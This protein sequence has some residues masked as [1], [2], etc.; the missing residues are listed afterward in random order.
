MGYL[1][2]GY[3]NVLASVVWSLVDRVLSSFM[4]GLT[5]NIKDADVDVQKLKKAMDHMPQYSNIIEYVD[6]LIYDVTSAYP[7]GIYVVR[8]DPVQAHFS[9]VRVTLRTGRIGQNLTSVFQG[10]CALMQGGDGGLKN[11]AYVISDPSRADDSLGY[12]MLEFYASV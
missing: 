12:Y 11:W 6:G 1:L 3:K 8:V 4:G 9:A 2:L 7:N 10:L 5:D